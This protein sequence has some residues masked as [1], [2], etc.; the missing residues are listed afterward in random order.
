[1]S[2]AVRL[3]VLLRLAGGT[4][5]G[6]SAGGGG[7]VTVTNGTDFTFAEN[8]TYFVTVLS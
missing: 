2:L 8:A 1:M 6:G 4:A 5:S 7:G 3:L